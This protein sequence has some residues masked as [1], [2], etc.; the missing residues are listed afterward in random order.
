MLVLDLVYGC[1]SSIRTKTKHAG[2][3]FV[4]KII[5][6]IIVVKVK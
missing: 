2:L 6:K 1:Q 3:E 5:V 4:F